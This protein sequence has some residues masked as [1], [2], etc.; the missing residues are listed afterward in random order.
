MK[1]LI[2]LLLMITLA[3]SC[4]SAF[5]EA[6]SEMLGKADVFMAAEE[7]EKAIACY[8]IAQRID[9]DDAEGFLGE[10]KIRLMLEQYDM[11]MS[12]ADKALEINP[13]APDGWLIKCRIDVL[14]GD[15]SAFEADH[16]FAS[17]CDVDMSADSLSI[18]LMY[19]GAGMHEKAAAYFSLLELASLT[20]GQKTLYRRSL[21]AIGQWDQAEMPGLIPVSG[22]NDALD[23]MFEADALVLTKAETPSIDAG[24]FEFPAELWSAVGEDAP[25]DPYA[26]MEDYLLYADIVWLSFSPSKHSG[27]LVADGDTLI[28]CFKGKYHII[29]PT[30]SRGVEDENGNLAQYSSLDIRRLLGE[31]GVVYSSDGRYAGI[32]NYRRMMV[33]FQWFIDPIVIDLS[34]GEMFLSATYKNKT[35]EENAG[36]VTAAT[37]SSD[38]RYLHYILFGMASK[39]AYRTSLYRYNLETSETEF[40]YS[41]SDFTYYPAL[42]ETRD[43]NFIILQDAIKGDEARGVYTISLQNGNW[44]GDEHKFDLTSKYWGCSGLRYSAN[45]GYA[46]VDGLSSDQV[47]SAFKCFDPDQGF[48][49]IEK[50]Y[51]VSKENNQIVTLSADEIRALVDEN[52]NASGMA[53]APSLTRSSPFHQIITLRMSPDGHYALLLTVHTGTPDD[54]HYTRHLYLVRL[55][56]MAMR[57]VSGVDPSDIRTDGDYPP[58]I[59]WNTDT[60]LICTSSGVEA[61][62]FQ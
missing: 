33:D 24:D 38:G 14:R 26:E 8:Q 58:V 6:F 19:A 51:A 59:E 11:A 42:A 29:Y 50:Y 22:R 20:E 13:V 46:V 15:I 36:A 21:V 2:A 57:E 16:L 61:Y 54:R 52:A 25:D 35:R 53:G 31:E 1:R 23:A 34:T 43:G 17:V 40:C 5:A 60:I 37:F 62:Q 47:F 3:F 55:D 12:L 32:Y 18:A 48:Q 30:Q 4:H 39:P 45:S 27:L 10:A 56:D 7:Y 9:P 44:S 49:G 28:G 41:G